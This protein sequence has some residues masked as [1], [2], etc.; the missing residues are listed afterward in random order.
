MRW[1]EATV[2]TGHDEI[3]ALCTELENLGVEGL[4]IEDEADF[5]RFLEQNRDCW[6]YVDDALRARFSGRSCVKFYV[7]DDAAGRARLAALRASLGRE[8]LLGA[9][10]DEDWANSWRRYYAPLPVGEKLLIVPAWMDAEGG[11]RTILRLEP[12]LGFGTGSHETTRMCLEALEPLCAPGRRVLDLGTGSGILAIAAVLL[13]CDGAV[14]CDIDPKAR[15]AAQENAARNGLGPERVRFR[16]GDILAD[17]GLRRKLGDAYDIVLSNIVADVI[18]ALAGT[19]RRFLGTGAV[20]ICS[21]ILDERESEVAAAIRANGF[22]IRRRLSR[23]E[24]R[25][26][27]CA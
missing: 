12:G 9:V 1:I 7:P 16:A 6:D 15:D 20:W 4:C 23:G 22:V 26:F 3:D 25:A 13:G 10:D 5:T 11:G 24:W 19:V 18:I 17:E 27:V 14:G 2:A 21:G 8:L